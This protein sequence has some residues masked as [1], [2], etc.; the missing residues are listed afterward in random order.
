MTPGLDFVI[1]LS[2]SHKTVFWRM[3]YLQK[4]SCRF[5]ESS[6][7]KLW[8]QRI[9]VSMWW[10]VVGHL[11]LVLSLLDQCTQRNLGLQRELSKATSKHST[12]YTSIPYICFTRV[13]HTSLS[14]FVV[15][16]HSFSNWKCCLYY[17]WTH[18]ELHPALGI[19]SLQLICEVHVSG[20]VLCL[21]T[22][23]VSGE[24]VVTENC[25]NILV[26]DITV[27]QI[28]FVSFLWM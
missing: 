25:F 1:P 18:L 2:V 10:D 8:T 4:A 11:M 17:F 12:R 20:H 23:C 19:M 27:C 26:C 9:R 28:A 22:A 6:N 24:C 15:F 7:M 21:K 5:D 3:E 14:I 16:V 13:T